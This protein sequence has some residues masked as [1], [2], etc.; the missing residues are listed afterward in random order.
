MTIILLP[1]LCAGCGVDVPRGRNRIRCADC[2]RKANAAKSLAKYHR[3][4]LAAMR[5]L[6]AVGGAL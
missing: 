2:R 1:I 5:S 4:K 3:A 6:L